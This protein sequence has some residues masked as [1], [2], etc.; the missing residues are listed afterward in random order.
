MNTHKTTFDIDG[1][2]ER[3]NTMTN[4]AKLSQHALSNLQQM[5]QKICSETGQN[6]IL[7]AYEAE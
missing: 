5:E 2:R 6:I 4:T 7:I 1:Q 3:K